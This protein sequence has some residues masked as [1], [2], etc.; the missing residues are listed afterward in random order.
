M[1][2]A[3]WPSL[4]LNTWQ[5]T[6]DT[7]HM[8]LQIVGKV[9]LGLAPPEPEFGHVAL[10]VTVR[11]LTTSPMPCGNRTAQID[12]D[13]IAHQLIVQTSDGAVRNITLRPRAVADFYKE[14]V[15]LL[16]ELK[17]GVEISPIPQEVPDQTPFDQD[18]H[19]ASY[20]ADSVHRFWRIL[21]QVDA[22][23]KKHRAPFRGRHTPVNVFWGGLDICYDRFSGRPASPPPGA[24]WLFRKSM[25]AEQIYAGFWPGDARFPEPAFASYVYPK[26]EDIE[27]VVI[28]PSSASW[29][30]QLGEFILPYEDMRTSTSPETTLMDFFKSTY[31]VSAG[32]GKWDRKNLE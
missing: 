16:S 32:L 25:D 4:P 22:I 29:S 10:Y 21:S 7:L 13:F 23:L 27:N 18:R 8:L 14:F 20:D 26:P 15:A 3:T 17:I 1:P 2:D 24:N 12:F 5:D 31:E 11:G 30:A 9:R 28:R 6:H 19:H